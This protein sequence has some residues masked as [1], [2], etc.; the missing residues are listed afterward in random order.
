MELHNSKVSNSHFKV[1]SSLH[2]QNRFVFLA[3]FV[4][5]ITSEWAS[6][7]RKRVGNTPV[8]YSRGQGFKYLPEDRL[9]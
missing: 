5:V 3:I 8:S 2:G 4:I 7:R 6:E 9:F 1:T